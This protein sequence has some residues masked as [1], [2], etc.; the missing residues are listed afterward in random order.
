MYVVHCGWMGSDVYTLLPPLV[1]DEVLLIGATGYACTRP[2]SCTPMMA[3]VV[4]VITPTLAMK[5]HVD[6]HCCVATGVT[7]HYFPYV[8]PG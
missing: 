5:H 3:V 1:V 8:L 6:G 7:V 4:V 2:W